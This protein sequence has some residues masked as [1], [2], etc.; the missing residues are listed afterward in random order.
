M[1]GDGNQKGRSIDKIGSHKARVQNDFLIVIK[2]LT[3]VTNNPGDHSIKKL[4]EQC[5][6]A[7]ILQ[8]IV[9]LYRSF[10][11]S[12]AAIKGLS[13]LLSRT[14]KIQ[15][16]DDMGLKGKHSVQTNDNGVWV[17]EIKIDGNINSNSAL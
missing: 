6:S 1:G 2:T 8:F 7:G 12:F 4:S 10:N 16:A 14:E 15:Y 5:F 17:V 11:F 9:V 13:L 3:S